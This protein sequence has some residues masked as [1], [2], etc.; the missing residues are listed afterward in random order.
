MLTADIQDNNGSKKKTTVTVGRIAH[1]LIVFQVKTAIKMSDLFHNSKKS[2]YETT[3]NPCPLSS[4]S[5]N[6][7][8]VESVVQGLQ[9]Q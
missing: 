5:M 4:P 1:H 8:D 7:N 2:N 6:A 3:R 9:Q